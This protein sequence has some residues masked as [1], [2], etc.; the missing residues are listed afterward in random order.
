MAFS[1]ADEVRLN[2]AG[3]ADT[4]ADAL[5]PETGLTARGIG[6]MATVRIPDGTVVAIDCLYMD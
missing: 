1:M 6:M 2:C 4:V 3:D 5:D